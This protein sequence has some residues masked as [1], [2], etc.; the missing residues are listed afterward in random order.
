MFRTNGN[1]R[2]KV[3]KSTHSNQMET[4]TENKTEYTEDFNEIILNDL[5]PEE[6]RSELGLESQSEKKSSG[7]KLNLGLGT[8]KSSKKSNSNKVEESKQNSKKSSKSSKSES[9]ENKNHK[10]NKHKSNKAS[11]ESVDKHKTS[12][13]KSKKSAKQSQTEIHEEVKPIQEV[14]EVTQQPQQSKKSHKKNVSHNKRR[15]KNNNIK[16][17]EL[18]IKSDIAEVDEVNQEEYRSQEN[19]EFISF[20]GEN[21]EQEF[22]EESLKNKFEDL[23]WSEDK[24]PKK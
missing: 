2:K 24:F 10:T 19:S 11:E 17:E 12:S 9:N 16:E 23:V 13:K 8:K 21:K 7:L 22:N 15:R 20:R 14:Q 4:I 3:S 6:K 18:E 1:R 5:V